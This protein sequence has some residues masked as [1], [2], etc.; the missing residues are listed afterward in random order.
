MSKSVIIRNTSDAAIS[1]V[2]FGFLEA[3]E[4]SSTVT[5]RV[6]NAGTES[7]TEILIGCLTSG[8]NTTGDRNSQGQEAV[9][10]QWVQARVGAGAWTPIGGSPLTPANVLSI[11]VP[12]PGAYTTVELRQVIPATPT[13]R[14]G[15]ACIPFALYEATPA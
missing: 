5:I 15:F 6:Y 12:S 11:A 2:E 7:P 1:A 13:T 3:G 8:W 14:G 9:T 10:E 4:T